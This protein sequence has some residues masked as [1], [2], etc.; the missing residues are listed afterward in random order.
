MPLGF[1]PPHLHFRSENDDVR[2]CHTDSD[3]KCE[4]KSE[5]NVSGSKGIHTG[6]ELAFVPNWANEL[7]LKYMALCPLNTRRNT[8]SAQVWTG[9]KPIHSR[10]VNSCIPACGL[11]HAAVERQISAWC[12]IFHQQIYSEEKNSS[13]E[14]WIMRMQTDSTLMFIMQ[15]YR[16]EIRLWPIPDTECGLTPFQMEGESNSQ[17]LNTV[18][19]LNPPMSEAGFHGIDLRYPNKDV[20]KLVSR[21]PQVSLAVY[22]LQSSVVSIYVSHRLLLNE[23]MGC[24][25]GGFRILTAMSRKRIT[26]WWVFRVKSIGMEHTQLSAPSLTC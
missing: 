13:G 12:L 25:M 2:W 26:L 7:P 8:I 19:F 20:S 4:T 22:I 23:A 16:V 14:I 24:K 10:I 21:G 17:H 5:T 6:H 9:S 11:A 15:K 3:A 1:S 18:L